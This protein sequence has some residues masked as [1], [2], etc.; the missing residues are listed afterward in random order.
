MKRFH[1][2]SFTF[3][4]SIIPAAGWPAETNN[5]CMT[6]KKIRLF[7]L[8][9][10]FT[11]GNLACGSAAAVVALRYDDLRMAFWL[12]VGAAVLDFLDGFVARL[13]K[14]YS[15]VGK[16]LDSL[17][18]MVSFGFA[19]GAVLFSMFVTTGGG[20]QWGL[21]VFVVTLFSAL[22]LAKFNVDETQSDSFVGLPTPACAL[23]ITAGGWLFAS[24]VFSIQPL[25]IILIAVAMSYFLV[26]HLRMF[27]LK[28][29][30]FGW[31]GNEVRYC[32]IGASAVGVA[33]FGIAAIPFI[34]LG[35]LLTSQVI[36]LTCK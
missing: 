12:V 35:Y 4:L 2:N 31:R 18:D 28:F 10:M 17:A 23:F 13:T 5:I 24:G 6:E 1:T 3:A 26:S 15:E 21:T 22:R 9:N 34:I 7:T 11:L 19:P 25:Y 20:W 33:V 27:A 36:A 30:S 14:Q 8:P 29:K 32:F 16:Q